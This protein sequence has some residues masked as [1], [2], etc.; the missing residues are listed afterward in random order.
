MKLEAFK[1]GDYKQQYQYR[2]FSPAF[3]N[4]AWNWDDGRVSTLLEQ[5]TKALGEL[6]A[7]S[8]IVPDVDLF[9]EMHIVKEANQ[10][11]R[12]EGTQT[13]MDEAV[14]DIE[15]IAPERR[16]DWQEV[17]NYI[18]AMNQAIAGLKT[19]PLSTR[20]IR[21]THA[22]L[23]SGVRGEHKTLG[24]FRVSQNWIGGSSCWFPSSGPLR[25]LQIS[26]YPSSYP[27]GS[28]YPVPRMVSLNHPWSLDSGNPCRNDVHFKDL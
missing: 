9:I 19:L 22:V 28:G 27:P 26:R 3:I 17:Q 15:Q 24:D 4:H 2:S 8:L 23:M 25:Y 14:M 18:Q 13:Q 21:Q 10:S 5:A 20:L 1:A 12:I 6:N 16:D 11:S 7:F